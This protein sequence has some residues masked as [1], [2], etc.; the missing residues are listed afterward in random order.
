MKGATQASALAGLM[1]LTACTAF[2]RGQTIQECF[3][4]SYGPWSDV[5][6]RWGAPVT[7]SAIRF[8]GHVRGVAPAQGTLHGSSRD[9][10]WGE[11]AA[12]YRPRFTFWS[13]WSADALEAHFGTGFGRLVYE[14]TYAG[15]EL[16]GKVAAV[17]DNSLDP[18]PSASVTGQPVPCSQAALERQGP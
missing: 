1:L 3:A 16:R 6:P 15:K 5:S 11:V 9:P 12:Q 8:E 2:R 10:A 4:L 7:P 13:A 17:S 18:R 14:F